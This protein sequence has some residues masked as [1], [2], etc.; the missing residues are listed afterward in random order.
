M[1]IRRQ[2]LAVLLAYYMGYSRIRNLIFRLQRKA[3]VRFVTFHDLLP[4]ELTCFENN[5][6]FLKRNTNVIS[7]DD[8]ISDRLSAVKINTVITFDDGYK[9]WVTEA[10]P[11]LQ[12]L[13]LPA[14][15]FVSSGFVGLSGKDEAIFIRANLFSNPETYRKITG[16]LTLEDVRMIV[17]KGFTIGGHTL[18]HCNL[19]ELRDMA[20]ATYEIA[21]D[22]LRLERMTGSEDRIFCLPFWS[23]SKSRDKSYRSTKSIGLQVERLL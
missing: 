23:L 21:E 14:T 1:A 20:K 19:A 8:F 16:S 2:D 15:F 22:K 10:I 4:E 3:V 13:K 17:E 7:L 6:Y 18:N 9:S 5:L 11:V 12:E